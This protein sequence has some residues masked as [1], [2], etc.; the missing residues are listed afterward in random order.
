VKPENDIEVTGQRGNPKS[1]RRKKKS[2]AISPLTTAIIAGV[3]GLLGTILGGIL[4]IQVESQKQEG[5]L[6][7]EGI[8][9]GDT[10]AAARNLLF[11]SDAGLIHLSKDQVEKL[12]T[13]AG[14]S[15]LPVLPPA[16]AALERI[17][18]MPS[19]ALT[20]DAK[21]KL[22]SALTL[23][24]AYMQRLGYKP[25]SDKVNVSIKPKSDM[26]EPDTIAIYDPEQ[27][28]MFIQNDFVDDIDIVL[29]Q[30]T[31]RILSSSVNFDL[32]KSDRAYQIIAYG[33]QTYFPCSF[34]N[35]PIFGRVSATTHKEPLLAY[36]L[37]NNRKFSELDPNDNFSASLDGPAIWG[38]AFWEI[39]QALGQDTT[40]RLLFSSWISLLSSNF[41]RSHLKN[42]L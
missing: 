32:R 20:E 9:T 23:Y 10:K 11:F 22:E 7:L 31:R 35:D 2:I 38:G 17:N 15:T 37:S 19:A 34:N 6:I 41:T 3:V 14:S 42:M 36:N 18:I 13:E 16:N 12:K 5:S 33:L 30:Y 39:R 28:T 1:R 4:N 8:K 25:K 29:Q 27:N 26:P 24:Q 21:K 40:D